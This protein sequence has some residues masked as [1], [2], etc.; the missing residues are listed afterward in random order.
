MT[1]ENEFPLTEVI[2]LFQMKIDVIDMGDEDVAIDR[3]NLIRAHTDGYIHMQ[4]VSNGVQQMVDNVINRVKSSGSLNL[5]RIWG[6]GWAGGQLISSDADKK[7]DPGAHNN[8]IWG[9][10]VYDNAYYLQN[11]TP[12]FAGDGILELHG[13]AVADGPEGEMFLVKLAQAINVPVAASTRVQGGEGSKINSEKGIGWEGDGWVTM[14]F[15]DLTV[16]YGPGS[17]L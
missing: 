7:I 15:P 11:L 4:P 13:C 14:A 9:G 8:Q 17:S 1:R 16:V 3:E 2:K 5:L 6:H 12:L 10:N